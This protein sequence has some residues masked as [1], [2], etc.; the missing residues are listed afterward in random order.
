MAYD[1]LSMATRKSRFGLVATSIAGIAIQVLS[2]DVTS[3][4]ISGIRIQAETHE[5]EYLVVAIVAMQLVGFLLYTVDDIRY[6]NP[7]SVV[8]SDLEQ[9]RH[10][11][12]ESQRRIESARKG[13]VS[14]LS[15]IEARHRGTPIAKLPTG[16]SL[17]DLNDVELFGIFEEMRKFLQERRNVTE[18]SKN[19]SDLGLAEIYMGD[20]L[21]EMRS[22]IQR[23]FGY[24]SSGD[25]LS[26]VR[27]FGYDTVLP[28]A[29]AL[30]CIDLNMHLGFSELIF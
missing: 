29:L 25:F 13:L 16:K 28:I 3:A 27:L 10:R 22:G 24:G 30:L 6:L 9:M 5:V 20:I 19:V 7:P 26:I 12:E 4:N 21:M 18:N 11:D 15:S 8:M 2:V 1:P 14:S 17:G 23:P